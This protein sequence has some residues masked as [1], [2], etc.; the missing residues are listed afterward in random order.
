MLLFLEKASA[1]ESFVTSPLSKA[2]GFNDT[3][4]TLVFLT[5]DLVP[6]SLSVVVNQGNAPDFSR[7]FIILLFTFFQELQL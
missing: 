6:S 3:G 2:Q 4:K 1:T 7:G 5:V